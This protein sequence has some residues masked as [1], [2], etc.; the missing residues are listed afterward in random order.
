MAAFT[1]EFEPDRETTIADVGGSLFNWDI[2]DRGSQ[3]AILNLG[4]PRRSQ[5]D[6]PDNFAFLRGDGTRLPFRDDSFDIGYSNSVVEHLFTFEQQRQFAEEMRRT[7]DALWVQ[8]PARPFPIEPHYLTPFVHFLPKR[9]QRKLLRNFSVWG[10][11]A[12]P[13]QQVVDANVEEIRLV[14]FKEMREL[15]PDCEIRREKA[16]FL[17]KS[18]IAVRRPA[19]KRASPVAASAA[20]SARV[21]SMAEG[22][23]A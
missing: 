1:A 23:E 9:L 4:H 13:S 14:N 6:S 21:P 8:T 10:W 15:F 2:F 12:R 5:L 20:A 18:Y 17:T 7:A 11:I 19:P 22:T 16:L 3:I